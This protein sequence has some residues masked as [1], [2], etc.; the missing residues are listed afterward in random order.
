ML[1]AVLVLAFGATVFVLAMVAPAHAGKTGPAPLS[2]TYESWTKSPSSPPWCL[3]EDDFHERRWGDPTQSYSTN[4]GGV[5]SGTFTASEYFCTWGVD[6]WNGWSSYDGGGVGLTF[7]IQAVGILESAQIHTDGIS[8]TYKPAFTQA[9]TF[10][11]SWTT[12]NGAQAKVWN[13]Y[14]ACAYINGQN[15][16]TGVFPAMGTW[17]AS[18]TGD[19]SQA[20]IILVA[21]MF[22]FAANYHWPVACPEGQKPPYDSW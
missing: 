20:K 17:T 13:E 8:G 14:T 3:S 11:R 15:N 7:N 1:K 21:E 5:F 4:A 2:L 18:F 16:V 12:G 6:T 9:V 22:S 10:V 19:F